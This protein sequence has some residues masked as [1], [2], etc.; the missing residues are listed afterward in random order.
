MKN[1]TSLLVFVG[2]LVTSFRDIEK[3]D[4]EF[5]NAKKIKKRTPSR[6]RRAAHE[7]WSPGRIP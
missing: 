7:S 2:D 5:Q 6:R 1:R 4:A 3:C